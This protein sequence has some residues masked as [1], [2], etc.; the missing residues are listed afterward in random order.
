MYGCV[1]REAFPC[2]NYSNRTRQEVS[3]YFY[4]DEE[5][6]KEE[7]V[8]GALDLPALDPGENYFISLPRKC[9][10]ETPYYPLDSMNRCGEAPVHETSP[11]VFEVLNFR[12]GGLSLLNVIERGG[13]FTPEFFQ[14]LENLFQGV[15]LLNG[16][17][18]YH[19]DITP[20]N[21]VYPGDGKFRL[22]DFGLSKNLHQHP[23]SNMSFYGPYRY[24]PVDVI[25]L[26]YIGTPYRQ[27]DIIMNFIQAYLVNC[28]YTEGGL[29]LKFP[30]N[31]R[32]DVK[33]YYDH[34]KTLTA[35][36]IYAKVD[37]WGLG[38]TLYDIY[39]V[40]PVGP[41]KTELYGLLQILLHTDPRKRPDAANA[42]L[43]YRQFL[44]KITPPL[45]LLTVPLLPVPRALG[46]LTGKTWAEIVLERRERQVQ[47]QAKRNKTQ[48]QKTP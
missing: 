39:L 20:R 38:A 37:V 40:V 34:I 26:N 41:I 42:L 12:D 14:T 45:P 31:N 47:R 4:S 6:V 44:S 33:I 19:L 7:Q 15:A 46:P 5:R 2:K 16:N 30:P 43:L 24:W 36:E 22:I 35:D 32:V 8:Y 48:K 13:P 11:G 18:R 1:Y 28:P 21:V 23:I 17:R 9:T 10:V 29:K 25:F 3:K 27:R